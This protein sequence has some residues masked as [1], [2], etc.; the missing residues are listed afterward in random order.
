LSDDHSLAR[1]R[2]KGTVSQ[3][4]H[5]V[6]V[7]QIMI[8]AGETTEKVCMMTPCTRHTEEIALQGSYAPSY[9]VHG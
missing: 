7:K 1:G 9:S 6:Q 8:A 4:I 5:D 3:N 2:G